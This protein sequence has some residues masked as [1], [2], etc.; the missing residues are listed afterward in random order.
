M[1][2]Y[3]I[4]TNDGGQIMS[5]S[6]LGINTFSIDVTGH[7]LALVGYKLLIFLLFYTFNF[8]FI[9]IKSSLIHFVKLTHTSYSK[10]VF[11]CD[12]DNL[13]QQPQQIFVK[14]RS[15]CFHFIRGSNH[16]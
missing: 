4:K 6:G 11:V 7:K 2:P 8:F 10:S 9:I 14:P 3:N 12:L 13:D 16:I 1:E 15:V 5:L